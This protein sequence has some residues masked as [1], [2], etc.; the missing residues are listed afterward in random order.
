MLKKNNKGKWDSGFDFRH[1]HK[2]EY[3]LS[4]ERGPPRLVRTIGYVLVWE[5]ADL[6]E[7]VDINAFHWA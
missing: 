1:F 7:E 6:I 4:M 5:V 2:F 3:R